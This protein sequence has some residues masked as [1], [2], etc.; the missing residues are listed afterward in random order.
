M[1]YR[2]RVNFLKKE[3]LIHELNVRGIPAD[4]THTVDSLRAS[5]RPL[6]Q[7]EK[8]NKSLTY[9]P[10]VFDFDAEK[11]YVESTLKQAVASIKTVTG[12]KALTKFERYQTHLVHLLSRVDR[13]PDRKSVV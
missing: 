4:D 8:K 13:I 11:K 2:L 12:E 10:Y 9:P 7:L 3:M 6:L 5:L 1:D